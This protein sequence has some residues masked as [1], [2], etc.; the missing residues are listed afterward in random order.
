M[1][2]TTGSDATGPVEYFFTETTFGPGSTDSGW[3]TSASYTD[4][5]LDADTQ[6]TYTVQMRDSATTPNVGTA[7]S[8]ANATTD[9]ETDAPTPNPA[10][11]ASAPSADSSSA[12]SMTATTGSDQTGPVEYYFDET[13]GENGGTSSSWQTSA[14]YTDSGLDASTQYT[15]TVQMRDSATTP[16]VGTVS[17]PANATTNGGSTT[18]DFNPTEDA[19]VKQHKATIVTNNN[20]LRVRVGSAGKQIDSYLKFTVSGVGTVTSAKLNVYSDN[21]NMGVDVYASASNSWSESSII[22]DTAPGSTGSSVDFINVTTGWVEFDVTSL[23]TGNG[24]FSL[25]LKGD[26]TN[27]SRDFSS[28]EGNNAPILSVTYQ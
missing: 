21:V 22:W 11:F 16:N 5:G 27:G 15:Y 13:S 4:S 2:A 8:G 17:S 25:I 20:D 6:Y 10:T 14:S 3:Q 18:D 23:I 12:I 24:T 28:S 9:E 26:G 19:Y 7:S 1:T